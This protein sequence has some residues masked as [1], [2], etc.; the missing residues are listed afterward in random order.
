MK[1]RKGDKV[2]V[3][4]GK[5]KGKKGKVARTL[6]RLGKIIV[7]GVN[8]Q[9]K[10]VRSKKQGQKG[11]IVQV[12]APL[13]ISNLKVICNKCE[14]PTRVGYKITSGGKKNRI[15]KKCNGEI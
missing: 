1:I 10:H 13:D 2:L 12:A 11:Q 14:K 8:I 5:D 7:E 3:I 9:K 6:P 15:C 4:S